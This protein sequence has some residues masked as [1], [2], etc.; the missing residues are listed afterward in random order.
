MCLHGADI[1]QHTRVNTSIHI[2]HTH[3]RDSLTLVSHAPTKYTLIHKDTKIHRFL[4]YKLTDY[5]HNFI[6]AR[7]QC[8]K[9]HVWR[10]EWRLILRHKVDC[11]THVIKKL[12]VIPHP[13]IFFLSFHQTISFHIFFVS[14][15][16]LMNFNLS[17]SF[18]HGQ[19][20]R[21]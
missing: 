17:S 12:T 11:Y 21:R 10:I 3:S 13:S 6:H 15:F 5:R 20:R 19:P 1:I 2:K 14:F 18:C 4:L 7:N 8:I 9:I 16:I